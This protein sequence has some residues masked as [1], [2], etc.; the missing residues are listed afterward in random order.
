[1]DISVP[2]LNGLKQSIVNK[3]V[4]LFGLDQK[5]TLIA[6]VTEEATDVELV[7]SFDLLQ[8]G[9]QHDVST[10]TTH[11]GATVDDYWTSSDRIGCG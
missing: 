11:T 10:S 9:I 7:L 4:L 8:H 3:D 6:N 1:M 5:V 2:G